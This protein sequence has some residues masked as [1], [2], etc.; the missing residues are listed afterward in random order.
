MGQY[1]L[2]RMF[3][4]GGIPTWVF[5]TSLSTF[6]AKMAKRTAGWKIARV[7]DTMPICTVP[8]HTKKYEHKHREY[9]IV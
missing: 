2:R 1:R 9:R 3:G 7:S 4:G 8:M 5:D 6:T